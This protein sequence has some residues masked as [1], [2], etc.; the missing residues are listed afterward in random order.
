M[1]S[2]VT[3]VVTVHDPGNRL[4]DLTRALL[5]QVM[6]DYQS[7][8][9]Y[10]SA[11]TDKMTLELLDNLGAQ[12]L[13]DAEMP[14]G[15]QYLGQVRLAAIKAG[16]DAGASHIHLSDF[17]RLL[18]W[19]MTYPD[20]LHAMVR[21]IAANDFVVLGRTAR[22]FATHPGYQVETERLANHVFELITGQSW[23]VLAGSRGMS[24]EVGEWLLEHSTEQNFGVDAE[25]PVILMS[26]P[27]FSVAYHPCEGL[28]FETPDRFP[29]EVAKAGGVQ[30]WVA[31]RDR[32]PDA[33]ASRI[34]FARWA[35]EAAVRAAA[36]RF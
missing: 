5:P 36:R 29:D 7:F 25:W 19:Q 18:H 28:E 14:L 32:S 3:A 27:A 15:A 6:P 17:D 1:M 2:Q 24:R 31:Q 33:W 13:H 10:C 21:E 11:P 12:V 8:V 20:E 34:E 4:F 35:A 26:N 16:L 9:A 23:D 22:A 30:G